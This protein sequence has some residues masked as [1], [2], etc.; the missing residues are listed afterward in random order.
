MG[1]SS[2]TRNAAGPKRNFE[3]PLMAEF[4]PSAPLRCAA[5]ESFKDWGGTTS[6]LNSEPGIRSFEVAVPS[7]PT[8]GESMRTGYLPP[9]EGGGNFSSQGSPDERIQAAR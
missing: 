2:L 4:R 7:E 5:P 8:F 6:E 1:S 3:R 9:V